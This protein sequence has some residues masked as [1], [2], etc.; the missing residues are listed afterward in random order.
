[1]VCDV[2]GYERVEYKKK[3]GEDVK[4]FNI[5]VTFNKKIFEGMGCEQ[6]YM[7]DRRLNELGYVPQVGDRINIDRNDRGMIDSIEILASK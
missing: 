5:C 3:T 6:L 4:A 1:M 7:N 2:I